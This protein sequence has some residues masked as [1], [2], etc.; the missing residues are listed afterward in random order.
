MHFGASHQEQQTPMLQQI[1]PVDPPPNSVSSKKSTGKASSNRSNQ[2]KVDRLL[3]KL[4]E[5]KQLEQ[6]FLD[7]K[8]RILDEE[9]ADDET[10]ASDDDVG[11][12]EM[13]KV[14]GW[15][16]DTEKCGEDSDSGLVEEELNDDQLQ[17]VIQLAPT[18]GQTEPQSSLHGFVPNQRSTPQETVRMDPRLRSRVMQPSV[19]A[20]IPESL[21]RRPPAPVPEEPFRQPVVPDTQFRQPPATAPGVLFRQPPATAPGV[22]FRQPSATAPGVLFRQPSATAPGVLFRQPPATAPGVQFRQPSAIAPEVQFR[23]PPAPVPEGLLRR[24]P[25]HTLPE[26]QFYRPQVLRSAA[27]LETHNYLPQDLRPPPAAPNEHFWPEPTIVP[28]SQY[29]QPSGSRNEMLQGD[30]TSRGFG[31]PEPAARNVEENVCILNRSQLAARQAVSKELPEFYGNPEDWPLFF[32]MYNSST[33]MC[34]FS[35]EENMLR[36]RKCLKGKALDARNQNYVNVHTIKVCECNLDSDD[37][38]HT[39]MKNYFTLDSLG[40]AKP[41]KILRSTEEQR[42]LE[43]LEKLTIPKEGR[44]ETGLLW[45]YDDVRFPSSKGMA[46]RRWQ[47]LDR[48]MKRDE[49][50]AKTVTTKMDEYVDKRYVRKLSDDELNMHQSKEWYLPV[51]P[52]VNPNKPGKVR[53]VWDAAAPAYGVSLNSLLLKGPDLLTSLLAVL[54]QFREFRI[55]ICGDIREMY[56]QVLLRQDIRL[57]FFWKGDEGNADPK[58]YIML[59]LPFGVSCAPSIA[60]YVKNTNA[61]RFEKDHP[62]AVQAIVDQHYVD[63]MLVSVESEQEA[64]DLARDVKKIHHEAGF[65][66]RNWISNSPD[67][68]EALHERN[69]EEKDLNMAEGVITEKVLGMWWNTS[70]DCFTFKVSPRYDPELM[71][72]QRTPTKRE[73]LRTLMMIFDPLG[74]IGH[75]L[76]FLKVVLQEIWRT[77]VGW[78]DPIEEKQFEMWMQWL[79]VLPEVAKVEIPRCYRTATSV[80]GSN[81]VQMHIF[82][83]ASEKGFAA[84]VYLRFKEGPIIETALVGSK[85]RVAPIKF[86]SIP[87]SELQACVIG[88]R[89]ANSIAQSLSIKVNRRYFWTDSSDVISWLKSDHRRYSQFVAFRVSEILEASEVYEWQWIQTKKN[90]A[91]DGTKW[92]RVP[93]MTRTSRWFNGPEFLKNIEGEWPVE[94][95]IEG[96]T[97]EELRP[98]LLVHVKLPEPI[99]DLQNCSKWTPLVHRT[100]YVFRFIGNLRTSRPEERTIGVLTSSE[101]ATAENYLYRLAQGSSYPDEVAVLS[102]IRASENFTLTI[103]KN[104]SIYHL[105]PFLDEHDVLRVRGRTISCP[106]VNQDAVNPVILPRDHHITRLVISHYHSKYHHQNHNTVINELRQRYSIPRLKAAYNRI[107]QCC[108]QCKNDRA[109]PQPPAMSDLPLPRLAAYARPFTY[110]GV[111]YFGPIVI[112]LGRRL[113]KRWVLLAT[114]LTTRAIHLQIVQSMTTDSCIMA[115]R[116]VMARRGVPAVIYSD[117]GTNFQGASREL[118]EVMVNLDRERLAAEFTTSH[119]TWSFIPPASPHMGGAWERL[120]RTVKQNLAKLK[121]NRTLSHEVLENMLA[122]VENIV[123]SR[124]LTSIPLDDDQ[125]PVLTPN[126]FLLGSSNGLKPW[127]PFDDSSEVLKNCWELSQTLANQFWKQWLHDYL[128]SSTRRTKWFMEVKPIRVNDIVV[129][130]DPKLPRNTWPKGRVIGIKQ[131]S[132]G[133]VRSATVQTS[134]GIYE[135][136]TVKLAVLDVGVESNAHQ[137]DQKPIPGGECWLRY[138]DELFKPHAPRTVDVD[139]RIHPHPSFEQRIVGIRD[140]REVTA[141]TTNAFVQ[142]FVW[143]ILAYKTIIKN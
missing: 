35:N 83:D 29:R 110:M 67:V 39:A 24:S 57:C 2:R 134:G 105:C 65:E 91:D 135:R 130:V 62:T 15:L 23:R 140:N 17:A 42:A 51:F 133:Q 75:F 63:D 117:R 28:E 53:L 27:A 12:E 92:K 11:S 115:L 74:L 108:Q 136:P 41:E 95:H 116:N 21:F 25:S 87:R 61:Q 19:P 36:L 76:M 99:I 5:Q 101:L 13:S 64:V 119:T 129:I 59:V 106:F 124:P 84:V 71:S 47:C 80:G 94:L 98:H 1:Q 73:V 54:V 18:M 31:N 100:A 40:V 72:G 49:E 60:Q 120:V 113:E 68:L 82:V 122:E 81:E 70:T 104:S 14:R 37:N 55:A 16:R 10:V 111:D 52:V 97:T 43:M 45:K 118:E 126:H 90:V 141:E 107:R 6:K 132:D 89:F 56:L 86:L 33:K 88:V 139:S 137:D 22:Q 34:G 123:N 26:D 44:Y 103:P 142:S 128:P 79:K 46:Y 77:S 96:P 127:V 3:Q 58:V 32:S 8:Y 7:E 4:E 50:F 85:T 20:P 48:R 78:D 69:T 125:S 131:G 30:S 114:C 38:L 121:P 109:R 93:D 138:F 112:I 66:M 143:L 9:D 102:G